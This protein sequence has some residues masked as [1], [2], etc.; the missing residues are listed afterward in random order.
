MP[1][2]QPV[3]LP[4]PDAAPPGGLPRSGTQIVRKIE[5]EG[6][7][8]YAAESIKLKMR[9]KEGRPFDPSLLDI[10]TAMLYQFFQEVTIDLQDVP[11]GVALKFVV[12]ENPVV[13]DLVING[14][15]AIKRE[16]IEA[17]PL[18]TRVGFPRVQRNLDLD[19][20]D[21]AA[22]YRRRGY[23][24]AT[25]ASPVY[26][27]RLPTGGLRVV[28]TV[29]EG[30]QVKVDEIVLRGNTSVPRKQ[31]L[32]AMLT[33]TSKFLSSQY[34]NEETLRED[35]VE[36]RRVYRAEGYLDAEVVLE[37]LRFSDDKSE[38]VVTIAFT[39]GQQ[40]RVGA[41]RFDV[42]RQET[43]P[44]AAP[45][46]D[47]AY[48]TQDTLRDLLGLAPGDVYA[49]KTEERGR[50]RIQEAYFQRSYLEAS[51]EKAELLP[52][53]ERHSVDVVVRVAEGDKYRG[54]RVQIVGNEFTRDKI[55]RREITAAP[56]DYVDRNALDRGLAR[57][58]GL[59]YFDRVTRRFEDVMGPDGAPLPAQKDIVYEVVEG[60]TGKLNIG[61]AISDSGGL[62]ANVQ[63]LKKNFDIARPP[64]SFDD[65]ASGR[66]F[67]GA[68]QS[69]DIDLQPG[70][71]VSSFGVDFGEPRLFGTR[72][73]LR[74][75]A[76]KRIGFRESYREDITGYYVRLSHPVYESADDRW[77][78]DA[79]LT[80]RQEIRAIRDVRDGAVPGVFLFEG[81]RELRSLA[82][83]LAL[84]HVDDPLRPAD[85]MTTTFSF[86]HVGGVLGGELDY[87]RADLNHDQRWKV[88]EDDL[89]R[90]SW[91]S[92]S[93]TGGLA[94]AFGDTPEVPPY[95]RFYAGGRDTLRG[96]EYRGVGPHSNDRPMGGEFLL[97]A[98][99]QYERPLL[100]E[101][102]SVV[103]FVDTGTLSTSIAEGI[104]PFRVAVG[105]GIRL[106][107]PGIFTETPIAV[108][109]AYPL[110]KEDEDET[111]LISFSLT[112]DF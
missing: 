4:V 57:V 33:K 80:W 7:T 9:L 82:F 8:A 63:F 81:E 42:K 96:F 106:R 84:R 52:R 31:L 21:V 90:R 76:S 26:E 17:L 18:R 14:L 37:D 97:A 51:V 67:T 29:V 71:V 92:V 35:V 20:E 94:D 44:G 12:S 47:R 23:A 43:G 11:G 77:Q 25:V 2:P 15:E 62:S 111:R 50:K 3:P 75:G 48:F 105:A 59:R 34:F 91:L 102:L 24:F 108:D 19:R 103:G 49:G 66:A 1:A 70:T 45:P 32:D 38:V 110:R 22:A 13:R 36:L 46:E 55:I 53:V 54:A 95:S 39:E 40:Y 86:E 72:L 5:F 87:W 109:F 56:G 16:E 112:R 64:R 10:D 79:G 89:G 99:V 83:S 93:V 88:A 104:D 28:F 78:L 27:E 85:R 60:K 41:V 74:V 98:S 6:N 68:G 30:P 101:F 73:G 65:L 100:E 58:R 61:G 69:L 107:I